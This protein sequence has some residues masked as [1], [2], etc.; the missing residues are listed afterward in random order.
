MPPPRI[1]PSSLFFSAKSPRAHTASFRQHLR[2]QR[3]QTLSTLLSRLR[4]Q[5][6]PSGNYTPALATF[7]IAKTTAKI[8]LAIHLVFT[9]IG[10]VGPTHGISMVPTIPHSYRSTPMILVSHLHRRG[11]NIAVG[12]VVTF[13]TPGHKDTRGCKRVVGM[14]GDFVAVLSGGKGNGDLGKRDDE[15]DWA[16]VK[17]EVVRVPE[18]HVWLAGDNLDWSRDS[19]VFGAVPLNVVKGKV[20]AVVWPLDAAKWLGGEEG[21]R[22]VSEGAHEPLV[23]R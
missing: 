11:R 10:M 5:L 6:Q 14:P 13:D 7:R 21:L 16:N 23:T 3:T 1:R 20:L 19:R 22:D 8:F 15:G 12:D 4:L 18:G 9:Y 17:E 2:P